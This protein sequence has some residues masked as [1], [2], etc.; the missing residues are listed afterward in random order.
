MRNGYQ[1]TKGKR[2]TKAPTNTPKG[3][4]AG[5]KDYKTTLPRVNGGNE[6]VYDAAYPPPDEEIIINKN[7][8]VMMNTR[9][10][11]QILKGETKEKRRNLLEGLYN[12][13]QRVGI[14][15]PFRWEVDE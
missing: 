6:F 10:L 9:T 14:P 1:P 5:T 15:T 4:R 12:W 13:C 8:L 3:G 7:G 11:E 2:V